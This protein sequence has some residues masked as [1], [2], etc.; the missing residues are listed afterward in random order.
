MKLVYAH[1]HIMHQYNHHYFSNGS[2]SRRVLQRYTNIFE[3]VRFLSRQK[4]LEVMPINM[5]LASTE[6]VEF[7]GV[8]NFKSLKKLYT[9][10]R[11]N[12]IIKKEIAHCDCLIARLPSSIGKI[13]I[14]HAKHYKKPYLIEVVGCAWDANMNHG[15]VLGKIIAP[16]EAITNRCYIAQSNYTIYI[17]KKFLQSRYPS[18]GKSVVCPNVAIDC[19]ETKTLK[20]RIEKIKC[21]KN[22][23]KF[24]LIGSLDVGY[25]G[26]ETVIK[27]LGLI[28]NEL[29]DFTIEFLGKG[30]SS[31]WS[32]LIKACCLEDHVAFIG[33][34]PSGKDV[35]DWMDT[36]DIT[37]QPSTAEAQGRCIIEAMSRG[38][39]VIASKV[40]GIGELI[41]DEW[42]ISP[43]DY[44]DLARK[45]MRFMSDKESMVNQAMKNFHKAKQYYKSRIEQERNNFLQEFI[46]SIGTGQV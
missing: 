21:Q 45:I 26:H 23:L 37:L 46:R 8:P 18:S 34:L 35:F 9:L 20:T 36:M 5:S 16:Y 27:A 40:G 3:E 24:G 6:R 29:P 30:N 4:E 22:R 10:H 11:A 43:K 19:V 2:F 44:R 1:D 17:T 15:S 33:S 14:K 41:D 7:I 28:K 42:L 12:E 31:R 39:P 13:A 25:K 38:C 32:P